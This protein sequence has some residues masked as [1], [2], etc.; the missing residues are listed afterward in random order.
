MASW[1]ALETEAPRIAERGRMLVMRTGVGEGML[2]SVAGEG[3]P[4]TH[5]V[6]VAIVEGRLVVFSGDGSPKT[7]ELVTDGRYAFHAH[8]DPAVP[9]EFAIRGRARPVTDPEVREQAVAIWPFD[10]SDGYTLLELDIEHALLGERETRDAW[11]PRYTTWHAVATRPVAP[12]V[13][14]AM[15]PTRATAKSQAPATGAS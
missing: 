11:P 12:D 4:R 5:P 1:T 6:V 7:R 9:H 14:P 8:L 10:A 13:S 2:T 15:D 3:L